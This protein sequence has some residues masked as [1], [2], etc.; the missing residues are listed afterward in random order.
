MTEQSKWFERT[1]DF[2]NP[3]GV[4]PCILERLRGTPARLE[5]MVRAFPPEILAVKIE[6]TWSIQEHAGHLFDLDALHDARIDDFLSGA[7]LL[8]PADLQNRKTNEAGHNGKPIESI[9][10]SFRAA[11]GNFVGRLE[12]LEESVLTRTAI[13]PRLQ[14]PMRVIDMALFVAEHDDHHAARMRHLARILKAGL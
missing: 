7:A 9:L 3:P 4:F 5:E 12:A 6:G 8:R 13:H 10:L 2:T 11:R 1:F 14:K